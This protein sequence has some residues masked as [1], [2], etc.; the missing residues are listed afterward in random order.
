MHL[1][2]PSISP[3]EYHNADLAGKAVE[4]EMVLNSVS[5][6]VLPAVDEEIF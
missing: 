6:Q 5:E 3:E 4:F 2:W 1:L